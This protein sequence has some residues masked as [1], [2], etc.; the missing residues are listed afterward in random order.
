VRNALFAP[1]LLAIAVA[2]AGCGGGPAETPAWLAPPSAAAHKDL[3]SGTALERFFP[4]VD[5]TIYHY[6][7]ENESG[8]P[9]LLMVRAVRTSE[10]S[11]ELRYP[12]RSRRIDYQPD[13][14]VAEVLGDRLYILKDPITVGAS[15]RGENG[16]TTRVI[17]VSATAD[18]PA[19]HFDG[20]IQTLEERLGDHPVKF[21]TT[22]C[23]GVGVVLL[24]AASGANIDRAVLKSYGAPVEFAPDGTDR[25]KVTV[26]AGPGDGPAIPPPPLGLP[27]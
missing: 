3:S 19:G 1:A 27:P 20:C 13:G 10:R 24:E 7:T 12:Q 26:P 25:F 4:L 16:G 22:Y 11:G 21:A 9:G 15:W 8:E 6:A 18:V 5:G 2:L 17:S 23:P 14:V